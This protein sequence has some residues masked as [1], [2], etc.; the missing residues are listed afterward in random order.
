MTLSHRINRTANRSESKDLVHRFYFYWGHAVHSLN[1]HLDVV[2]SRTSDMVIAGMMALLLAD[3]SLRQ[4]K[5]AAR[6]SL[7]SLDSTGYICQLEMPSRWN[8]QNDGLTRR[9]PGSLYIKVLGA[10]ISLPLGVSCLIKT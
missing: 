4:R 3:V 2:E 8:M 6:D 9:L 10:S 5:F 1:E 7:S